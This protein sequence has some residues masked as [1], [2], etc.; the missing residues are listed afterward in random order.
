[1]KGKAARSE[2]ALESAGTGYGRSEYSPSRVVAFEPERLALETIYLKYEWRSTLCRLGVIECV[3]P[4][5]RPPNRLWDNAG[6]AP[7]P[8]FRGRP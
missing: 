4:P 8:P 7:P 1:M 5:R 6:Y 2:R 3:Q